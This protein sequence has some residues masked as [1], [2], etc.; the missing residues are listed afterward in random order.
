VE[1]KINKKK[2]GYM[3]AV[4]GYNDYI[5]VTEGYLESWNGLLA[6]VDNLKDTLF[7]KKN[8]LAAAEDAAP[9]ISSYGGQIS[10]FTGGPAAKLT[11]PEAMCEKKRLLNQEIK[12][13]E[14]EI[15][16]LENLIR[17]INRA[18]MSLKPELKKLVELRY[19]NEE[20]WEEIQTK[21]NYTERWCRSLLEKAVE[22]IAVGIFGTRAKK[23]KS[24]ERF[25]FI[26]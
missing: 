16:K 8:E 13:I 17:K 25:N 6:A 18:K 1:R 11:Q 10:L 3:R 24:D 20:S 4:D 12:G 5:C 19:M 9:P 7:D 15:R 22:D 14:R 26:G 21:L 2:P 23:E